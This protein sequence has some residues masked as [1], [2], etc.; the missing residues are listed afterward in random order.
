M[1]DDEQREC[2][3]SRWRMMGWPLKGNRT[4][5]AATQTMLAAL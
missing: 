5:P 4:F 3:S 2:G 1:F